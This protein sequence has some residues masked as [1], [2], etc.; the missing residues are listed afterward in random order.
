MHWDFVREEDKKTGK[1]LLRGRVTFQDV[2][3]ETVNK[4]L[5]EGAESYQANEVVTNALKRYILIIV[6]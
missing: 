2:M 1:V 4:W 6:W 3:E 5:I